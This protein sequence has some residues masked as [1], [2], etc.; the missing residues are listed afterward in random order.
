MGKEAAGAIC[1]SNHLILLPLGLPG[2]WIRPGERSSVHSQYT[3]PDT[4]DSMHQVASM[5]IDTATRTDTERGEEEGGREG[6]REGDKT[7]GDVVM[8]VP[9]SRGDNAGAS[10]GLGA[11]LPLGL[12]TG[13]HRTSNSYVRLAFLN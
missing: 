6:G 12:D 13:V 2:A 5:D 8:V 4:G 11:P 9:A 1:L 10:G 7:Y 3:R